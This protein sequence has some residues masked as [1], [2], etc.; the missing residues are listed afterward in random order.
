MAC[1]CFSTSGKKAIEK[2]DEH[3]L[4]QANKWINYWKRQPNHHLKA[5]NRFGDKLSI[6]FKEVKYCVCISVISHN[7]GIV[8]HNYN[9]N[10]PFGFTCTV[11]ET[12]IHSISE[13]HGTIIDLLAIIH[14]YSTNL[15]RYITSHGPLSGERLGSIVNGKMKEINDLL[16]SYVDSEIR[17]S[18]FSFIYNMIDLK[19]LS[20]S[21][22]YKQLLNQSMRQLIADYYSDMS[23]KDFILLAL[24]AAKTIDQTDSGKYSTL[25]ITTGMHMNWVVYA[26]S[27]FARN[28][29][30]LFG[31]L[32]LVEANG[33]KNLPM[34]VYLYSGIE[35]IEHRS[36]SMHT[37]P[38]TERIHYSATSRRISLTEPTK[39]T[40]KVNGL[41]NTPASE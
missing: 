22:E 1:L 29:G 16:T 26:T 21:T 8:F 19:R 40:R 10:K 32:D 33:Q 14:K 15:R 31:T 6:T 12:L 9:R 27:L 38:P 13:F 41:H 37:F 24:A 7:T 4:Q 30:E 5:T 25:G 34:I 35:G 3:N 36:P 23:A 18:D 39:R 17:K 20:A 2:Q 28:F 11:P